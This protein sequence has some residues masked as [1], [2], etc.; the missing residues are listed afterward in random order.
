[1]MNEAGNEKWVPPRAAAAARGA[2][3]LLACAS[4]LAAAL[5]LMLACGG[6]AEPGPH[7]GQGVVRE[8]KSEA[9]QIV[10]EHGDIPGLMKAMTMGFD[11]EDPALLEGISPGQAIDFEV[12]YEEG[13][14]RVT[15][16]TPRE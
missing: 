4:A 14:H 1:M 16:I 2:G 9:Q 10:I 6:G 15:D 5:G 11:V 7:R 3:R 8:V 12:V 13:R